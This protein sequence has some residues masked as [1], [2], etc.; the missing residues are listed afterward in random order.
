MD[1]QNSDK[2]PNCGKKCIVGTKQLRKALL[3]GTVQTVYLAQNA[4]PA[5]TEP[6]EALCLQN[7]IQ[8]AWVPSMKELG[9][10]CG[11]QVG[12]SAAAILDSNGK[13]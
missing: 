6:L 11:I 8:P 13:P 2:I 1:T 7:G 5:I 10:V 4:D 3:A 9:K 12:A